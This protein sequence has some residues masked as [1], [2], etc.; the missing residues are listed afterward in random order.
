VPELIT[1]RFVAMV[2]AHCRFPDKR[3]V[4]RRLPACKDAA[5]LE[6]WER[7]ASRLADLI[8]SREAKCEVDRKVRG[9]YYAPSQAPSFFTQRWVLPFSSIGIHGPREPNSLLDLSK[10]VGRFG[11]S[12]MGPWRYV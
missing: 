6:I 9:T 5:E 10:S 3:E 11:D 7:R 12:S 8:L 4:T 2:R 1:G